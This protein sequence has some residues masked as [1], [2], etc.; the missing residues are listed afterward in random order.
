MPEKSEATNAPLLGQ[1]TNPDQPMPKRLV[2][3]S[4]ENRTYAVNIEMGKPL[5]WVSGGQSLDRE[6]LSAELERHGCQPA[7]I[8]QILQ[9]VE[10]EGVSSIS[11]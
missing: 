8:T 1:T 5:K 6:R 4:N 7:A 2:I 11:L 3:A 9:E 10:T